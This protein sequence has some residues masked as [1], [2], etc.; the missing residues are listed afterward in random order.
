MYNRNERDKQI[1]EESENDSF[2]D[3]LEG[4]EDQFLNQRSN[5]NK[6]RLKKNKNE[7][8]D[9]A[10]SNINKKKKKYEPSSQN[11]KTRDIEKIYQ[12]NFFDDNPTTVKTK[13]RA[14]FRQIDEN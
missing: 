11:S 8:V 6:N 3:F 1:F 2:N 5:I 12:G 7:N 14:R 4:N 10:L 13:T 9:V